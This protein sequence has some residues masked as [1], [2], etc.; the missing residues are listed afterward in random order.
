MLLEATTF[1][2]DLNESLNGAGKPVGT[3]L[4]GNQHHI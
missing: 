3:K 1:C 2:G 4:I